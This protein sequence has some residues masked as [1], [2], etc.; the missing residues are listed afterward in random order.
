[1]AWELACRGRRGPHQ[2]RRAAR[3]GCAFEVDIRIADQPDVRAAREI[4]ERELHMLDRGLVAGGIAGAGQ[5]AEMPGPPQVIG[6]APQIFAALV[7]DD[8]EL[9]ALARQVR[10]HLPGARQGAQVLEMDRGEAV[11]E[12]PLRVPPAVAKHGRK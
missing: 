3:A 6:F 4:A 12:D 2:H 5:G 1:M 8:A 11:V 9:E 10:Q 7:A